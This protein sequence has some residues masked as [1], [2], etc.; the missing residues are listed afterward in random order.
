M[1]AYNGNIVGVPFEPN[2]QIVVFYDE[3]VEVFE[4]HLALDLRYIVDVG[5]MMPEAVETLPSSYWI[6]AN[7]RVIGLEVVPD[8]LW[9]TSLSGEEF[10]GQVPESVDVVELSGKCLEV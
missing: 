10:G 6:G 2:L 8:V 1:G 4:E 9:S 5:N 3:L 7:D